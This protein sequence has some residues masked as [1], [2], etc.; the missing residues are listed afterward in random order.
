MVNDGY[1]Q[2]K[3]LDI[4]GLEMDDLDKKILELLSDDGRKSYRKI[5]RELGVSVGTVH[6]RVD[7]LT[8]HGIITKFVPVINHE[9]LG[10]NL[11]AIIGLEIKGGT[12][13]FLVE[14]D[15][16]QDN[17]LA[18]YGVTGQF[19]GMVIAK[20]RNTKELDIF[21]KQL[22]NE[23]TVIKTYTQTVLDIVKEEL[24]TST[25]SFE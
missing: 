24:N 20:F 21:I 19:D 25:I 16:Y 4:I 5:S 14:N 8:K 9:K 2:S 17:I 15:V 10:Y 11:T 1:S 18:V 12:V 22:L 23:E 6:N 7:K 3:S 13:D